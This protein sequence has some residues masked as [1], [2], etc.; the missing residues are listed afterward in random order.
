MSS[1]TEALVLVSGLLLQA[2]AK[3][4]ATTTEAETIERFFIFLESF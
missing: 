4:D 3:S 1:S 2:A